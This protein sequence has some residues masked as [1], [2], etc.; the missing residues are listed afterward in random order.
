MNIM[1]QFHLPVEIF[2]PVAI[3][4]IL[5]TV[6]YAFVHIPFKTVIEKLKK[7]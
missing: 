4:S 7:R 6:H 2:V 1:Q 5:A 3:I